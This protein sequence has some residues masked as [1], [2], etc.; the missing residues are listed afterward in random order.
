MPAPFGGV[1]CP[2][3]AWP[4]V[5]RATETPDAA[6]AGALAV[7][8]PVAWAADALTVPSAAAVRTAMPRASRPGRVAR[9]CMGSSSGEAL[10]A[11]VLQATRRAVTAAERPGLSGCNRALATL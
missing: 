5:V 4:A 6:V 3:P 1:P 8:V 11:D 9:A 7:E 2:A 10:C